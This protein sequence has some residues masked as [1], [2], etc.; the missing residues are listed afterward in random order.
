[1]G[2]GLGSGIDLQVLRSGRISHWGLLGM[3]ER[4]AAIGAQFNITEQ[5]G[6]RTE[7][8]ITVSSGEAERAA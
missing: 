2:T 3:R 5:P 4:A 6:R 1:M 8:E 7:V